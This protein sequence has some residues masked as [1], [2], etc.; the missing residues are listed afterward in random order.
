ME[1]PRLVRGLDYYDHTAFEFK[2]LA[3]ASKA[4]DAVL[5][6]GYYGRLV[7]SLG[8]PPVAGWAPSLEP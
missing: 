5:A 7:S 2:L 4:Q 3:K 6:G 8:G 1:N